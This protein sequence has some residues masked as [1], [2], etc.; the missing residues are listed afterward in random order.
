MFL[1]NFKTTKIR[2]TKVYPPQKITVVVR[3]IRGHT[4]YKNTCN[5]NQYQLYT[6]RYIVFFIIGFKKVYGINHITS[7]GVES[8]LSFLL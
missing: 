3:S 4:E 6:K 2:D 1:D 7:G 5:P 8:I